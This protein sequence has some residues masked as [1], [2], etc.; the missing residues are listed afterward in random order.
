MRANISDTKAYGAF[1]Q[2]GL[3]NAS[4]RVATVASI[5]INANM[6]P[7]VTI[8]PGVTVAL[9]VTLPLKGSRFQLFILNAAS[10]TGTLQI[11]DSTGTNIGAAT[12]AAGKMG[13]AIDDGVN[14]I[15]GALT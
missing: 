14:T 8:D 13:I 11:K 5:T 12:L 2:P 7:V 6:G 3:K 4:S 10:A 9:A 15:F 1:F